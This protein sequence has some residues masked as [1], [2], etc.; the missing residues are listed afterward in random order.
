MCAVSRLSRARVCTSDTFSRRAEASP[1]AS[2]LGDLLKALTAT[3]VS[4][5][6]AQVDDRAGPLRRAAARSSAQ[7]RPL[8]HAGR[9]RTRVARVGESTGRI[10]GVY[11][12][13]VVNYET[14]VTLFDDT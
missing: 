2:F 14:A 13:L 3:L 5:R 1:N 8:G 9:L 12:Q 10:Q 11:H 6:S 4:W 7:S